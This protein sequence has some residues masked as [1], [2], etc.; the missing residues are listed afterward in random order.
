MKFRRPGSLSALRVCLL[1]TLALHFSGRAFASQKPES[2]PP[3]KTQEKKPQ[4]PFE[5]VPVA[6]SEPKP[7]PEQPKP[8]PGA[9]PV[10]EAPKPAGEAP[11]TPTI[12]DVIEA[13]EFRG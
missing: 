10:F 7:E 12:E 6:P 8:T 2:A 4:S 11:V 13:I 3:A 5:A 1:I 9:K